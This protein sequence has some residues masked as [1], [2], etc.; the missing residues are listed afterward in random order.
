MTTRLTTNA[1]AATLIVR[2]RD[3]IRHLESPDNGWSSGLTKEFDVFYTKNIGDRDCIMCIIDDIVT[4]AY[5]D[6][7]GELVEPSA[8]SL[9]DCRIVDNAIVFIG[10]TTNA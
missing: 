2:Y 7:E 8:H 6:E 5:A 1:L 3:L 10:D 4:V 9:L